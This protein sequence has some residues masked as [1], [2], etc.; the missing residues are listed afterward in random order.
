MVV[1]PVPRRR[2]DKLGH[3]S[4]QYGT[5][6]LALASLVLIGYQR[7]RGSGVIL[8]GGSGQVEMLVVHGLVEPLEGPCQVQLRYQSWGQLG[9]RYIVDDLIFIGGN[10]RLGGSHAHGIFFFLRGAGVPVILGVDQAR[11][12]STRS[13]CIQFWS[14]AA[15]ALAASKGEYAKTYPSH[16]AQPACLA[17]TESAWPQAVGGLDAAD[18]AHLSKC[19]TQRSP[20]GDNLSAFEPH[21]APDCHPG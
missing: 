20:L 8:K 6:I 16:S 19:P 7:K 2:S 1:L 3:P 12:L 14:A 4:A 13:A 5:Q 15:R 10:V 11:R 21:P 17:R 9:G 18:A